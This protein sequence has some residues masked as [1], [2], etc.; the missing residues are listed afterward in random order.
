MRFRR[1]IFSRA[2][3]HLLIDL[4]SGRYE[5][6]HAGHPPAAHFRAGSG[7]WEL[8]NQA[9][10]PALGIVEEAGYH[11][12]KGT[13][14]VGDALMM[15]TDG[16]VENPGRDLDLGIDRLLGDATALVAQTGLAQGAQRLVN[17]ADA[18]EDDDRS[19]MLI[20]RD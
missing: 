16:L 9:G 14:C 6:R 13:L 1:P 15:Y 11:P 17:S 20:W 10:G 3:T 8:L 18:Q 19:L 2:P 4:R 12:V 5:I 7:T